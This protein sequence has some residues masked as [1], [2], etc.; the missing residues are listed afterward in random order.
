VNV[1]ERVEAVLSEYRRIFPNVIIGDIEPFP[2]L[3][4]QQNWQADYIAWVRV[5][6]QMVGTALAFLH[7]DIDWNAPEYRAA[8][9]LAVSLAKANGL[10]VGVIYNGKDNDQS[11]REWIADAKAHIALVERSLSTVP[12]H[13]VFQS[14]VG[15]PSRSL[16]ESAEETFTH[17]INVYFRNKNR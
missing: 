11:D 15:Y 1:G 17:L 12:D 4:S 13:A 9:P 5:F 10:E 3:S 2:G 7:I 16:P 6:R 8:I 14:W